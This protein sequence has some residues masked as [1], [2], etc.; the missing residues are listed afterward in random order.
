MSWFVLHPP[1]K[2]RVVSFFVTARWAGQGDRSAFIDNVL[3]Q[4]LAMLGEQRPSFLTEANREMH[5]L[6]LL[7]DAAHA[8]RHRDE[9]LVLLIDGLDED[10]GVRTGPGSHSIA[11]LLPSRLPAGLRIIVSGRPSPPVPA[12]VPAHHPLRDEAIVRVLAPSPAAQAMRGEM[13]G[14]L[15]RLLCGSPV[16]R[17]LLGLITAAGGGLTAEDL[18]ELTDLSQWQVDE[19]LRTVTGRSFACYDSHYCPGSGPEVYLLGHEEL[20]HNAVEML[21]AARMEI[22]RERL[23]TWARHYRDRHW[24]ADTPEY[25]VRGYYG[26]LAAT[27]DLPRMVECAIDTDRQER[28]LDVSGAD[29]DAM[30]EITSAQDM[31][32]AQEDPDLLA[33][34]R[35]AIHRDRLG[36][37]STELPRFITLWAR[38]GRFARAETLAYSIPDLGSRAHKLAAVATEAAAKGDH[39]RAARLLAAAEST[40]RSHEDWR[41]QQQALGAVA[42]AAAQIGDL[43]RAEG[44]ALS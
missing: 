6:G 37:R 27:G 38:L 10:Q 22:Y 16:E 8:C 2:V 7:E 26:M 42:V 40:A 18:A 36:D 11:A 35:L 39:E 34:V 33:M 19:H 1:E 28:L 3:E 9:H 32:A 15:K 13:T 21:G 20:Q 41:E 29:S 4:L 30:L 14:E 17:D 24:P 44:I 31:I 5:L 43:N 12:D 23:H 25:L